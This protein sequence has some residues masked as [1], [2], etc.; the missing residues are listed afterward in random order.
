MAVS[1]PLAA[2]MPCRQNVVDVVGGDGCH[3][4]VIGF[5]IRRL[6]IVGHRWTSCCSLHPVPGGQLQRVVDA[7]HVAL[8]NL[9]ACHRRIIIPKDRIWQLHIPASGTTP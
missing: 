9:I 4:W 5:L 1:E 8:S 3:H 6:P 2:S 7:A